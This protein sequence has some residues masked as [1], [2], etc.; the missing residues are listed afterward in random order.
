[1]RC[2]SCGFENPEGMSFCGKCGT[3][4]SPSCP[5]CGFVNPPGFAFCGKCAT[6]LSA[7]MPNGLQGET[8]P[9]PAKRGSKRRKPRKAEAPASSAQQSPQTA[10]RA[11]PE[12]E[13]R[14]LT[15][16]FCDLVGSTPLAEKL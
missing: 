7:P 11:V 9:Q 14:Q 12:A 10:G 6:P 1:M 5:Q 3:A 2:A 16:M 13:R 15:V 8:K 4:L